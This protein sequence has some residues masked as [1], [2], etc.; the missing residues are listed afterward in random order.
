MAW[1]RIRHVTP[2]GP[3]EKAQYGIIREVRFIRR[4]RLKASFLL[5][6]FH[7]HWD[8]GYKPVIHVRGLCLRISLDYQLELPASLTHVRFFVTNLFFC[9]HIGSLEE[10]DWR[11]TNMTNSGCILAFILLA[12]DNF[13]VF[14]PSRMSLILISSIKIAS[15]SERCFSDQIVKYQ[16][17]KIEITFWRFAL[18]SVYWVELNHF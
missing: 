18:F 6:W 2:S 7:S 14:F 1:N 9:Y 17:G 5:I 12:L 8:I 15:L 3:L 13:T 16:L 10:W 4:G 11:E